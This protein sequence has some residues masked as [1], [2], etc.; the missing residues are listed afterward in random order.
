MEQPDGRLQRVQAASLAQ[1]AGPD[2][3]EHLAPPPV[4]TGRPLQE[5]HEA[6]ER[7]RDTGLDGAG[8]GRVAGPGGAGRDCFSRL[9]TFRT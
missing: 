2:R 5:V 3:G 1:L 6:R 8:V 7:H 4:L 9:L